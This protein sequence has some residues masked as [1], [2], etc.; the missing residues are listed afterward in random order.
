MGKH[1]FSL[2]GKEAVDGKLGGQ[3]HSPRVSEGERNLSLGMLKVS[4]PDRGER[5]GEGVSLRVAAQ[6]K[7]SEL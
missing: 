1:F 7:G 6:E 5:K 2:R 3:G 4:L